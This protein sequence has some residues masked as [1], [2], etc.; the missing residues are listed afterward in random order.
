[1]TAPAGHRPRLLVAHPSGELYGSDRVAVESV[2]ALA[3]AGWDVV[4]ALAADGP[5]RAEL[6]AVGGQVLVVPAP[7]LRKSFLSPL[8]VPRFGLASLRAVPALLRVLRRVRPD[9]VYVNT[10]TLPVWLA[11]SRLA[12]RPTL[13][14][15][16]EAEHDLPRA[17][18]IA[19]AA[20]LL[21]AHVVVA[22]SE[23]TREVLTAAVPPLA[24]R[25]RVVQNGVPGPAS[26]APPRGRLEPPVRLVVV[27]RVSPRKGTD[28]AVQALALLQVEGIDAC[29]TV[30]GGVFAGYEWFEREVR[31]TAHRLGVEGE[32][33]W[34][35]VLPSVWPSLSAA[36]IV[37]V[38]SLGESFGNAAVEALLAARPVVV[39]DVPGLRAVV[40]AGVP[41]ER[42]PPRD[43]AALAA[44]I[45]G[46]VADWPRAVAR[47]A[48]ARAE[49]RERFAPERY[50]REIAVVVNELVGV[51]DGSRRPAAGRSR[52]PRETTSAGPPA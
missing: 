3:G 34:A 24:R 47:A 27:G 39:S 52:R 15:V 29:L 11:V 31:E 21:C 5:L 35:G 33:Q 26:A 28:V 7:V 9:A 1:V 10:L 6:E 22:N 45:R 51:M 2:A 48:V 23:L 12:R 4:V 38:P 8:G 16:H 14:H 32:V 49:A 43:P 44:A 42:V 20:P 36:D 50:R 19:L 37:L 40:P 25:T 13:C 17:L 30:V 18:R 46:I 41:G